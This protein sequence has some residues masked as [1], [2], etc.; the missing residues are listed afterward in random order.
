MPKSETFGGDGP[1][2]Y[3]VVAGGVAPGYSQGDV[4]TADDLGDLLDGHLANGAI[5]V[6]DAA[7]ER[8]VASE[9]GPP[10]AANPTTAPN[11][12]LA[13]VLDAIQA[14]DAKIDALSAKIDADK[15]KG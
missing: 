2:F 14:I 6:A 8:V 7:T 10:P 11:V 4:V 13:P 5:E 15:A 9:P 1:T 12:N 3:R